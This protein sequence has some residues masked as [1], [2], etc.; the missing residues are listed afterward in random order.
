MWL[1]KCMIKKTSWISDLF[2]FKTQCICSSL[3]HIK[4]K[5][6]LSCEDYISKG[7]RLDLK[8]K[9]P[10]LSLCPTFRLAHQFKLTNTIIIHSGAFC[11]GC[12]GVFFVGFPGLSFL[13]SINPRVRSK[14]SQQTINNKIVIVKSRLE[15]IE[16]IV[17]CALHLGQHIS[18]NLPI[19]LSSIQMPFASAVSV[20]FPSV[21]LLFFFVSQIPELG[22]KDHSK[23]STTKQ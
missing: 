16:R 17:L 6:F 1:R 22:P 13:G 15:S 14:R 11:F 3:N 21:F 10:S 19:A 20:F 18:S 7:T 5:G 8:A 9:S 4:A 23:Q 2:V 12:L